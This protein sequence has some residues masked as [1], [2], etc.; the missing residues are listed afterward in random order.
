MKEELN[1]GA[2]MPQCDG[3]K[4][5]PEVT[6]EYEEATFSVLVALVPLV[7]FTFFGQVGLF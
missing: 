3:G 7:V 6:K 4:C 1:V 5:A 2:E